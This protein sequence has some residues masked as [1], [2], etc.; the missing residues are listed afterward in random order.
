MANASAP[1]ESMSQF[2]Q[3]SFIFA[4]DGENRPRSSLGAGG[5]DGRGSKRDK[6]HV[7]VTYRVWVTFDRRSLGLNVDVPLAAAN[8]RIG[9]CIVL[10][11]VYHLSC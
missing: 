11:S 4:N 5:G 10:A 6:D 8:R 2:G 1:Y 9:M 7:S 3:V